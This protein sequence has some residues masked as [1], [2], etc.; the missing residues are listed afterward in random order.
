MRFY[1]L[2]FT[3]YAVTVALARGVLAAE[4]ISSSSSL[5]ACSPTALVCPQTLL[6]GCCPVYCSKPLP[7]LPSWC[8]C[9]G[10]NDYCRKPAPG[11]SCYRNSNCRDDYCCKP[12][13][14]VCRPLSA[15]YFTCAVGS[16]DCECSNPGVHRSCRAVEATVG[17]TVDI[18]RE[19]PAARR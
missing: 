6:R 2:A 12:C 15:H 1:L 8:Y 10:P 11:V 3:F 16:G 4:T 17:T 5:D 13:P 14:D 7:G 19:L 9:P 18:D